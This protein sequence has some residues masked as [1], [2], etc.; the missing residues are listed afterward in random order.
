MEQVEF[1]Y[2]QFAGLAL[3]G[4]LVLLQVQGNVPAHQK[5]PVLGFLLGPPAEERFHPAQQFHDPER[6]G[7]VVVRSGVHIVFTGPGSEHD[8]REAAGGRLVPELLQ[9]LQAAFP[10][11]HN[12]QEH[13]IRLLFLQGLPEGGSVGKGLRLEFLAAQGITDQFP[14]VFIIFHTIYQRHSIAPSLAVFF[15]YNVIQE[16][17]TEGERL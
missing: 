7:N 4:H 6:F 9:D 3:G 10:R 2:G 13:Q 5:V 1:L 12:V 8:Y 17:P 14:D 16:I 15:H 11:E